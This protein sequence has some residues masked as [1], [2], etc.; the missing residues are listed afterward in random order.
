MKSITEVNSLYKTCCAICGTEDNAKELYPANIESSNFNP[1]VFSARRLPDRLHYRIVKCNTCGLVRSDPVASLDVIAKLYAQ[2]T[3]DYNDEVKGLKLTYGYYLDKLDKYKVQKRALL[4]IGCGNGF[5]LEE[6]LKRGYSTVK[7]VEPSKNAVSKANNCVQPNIICDIMSPGLFEP[8]YFDVICM[9][10]VLDHISNPNVLIKE[11]YNILKPG[12]IILCLNHN[13][14]SLSAKILKSRSPIIDI[15][16][17]YLFSPNTISHIFTLYN[18]QIKTVG[19]VYNNY[20][21]YYLIR[22]LP[23]GSNIKNKLLTLFNNIGRNIH[24][25]VPLGNLYLIAQK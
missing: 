8:E 20:S 23:L 10:Q 24:L 17:T 13:V 18:F 22:L 3:F 12:G 9:F 25:T 21:L 14:E 11:C 16:H 19:N 6:A 4:E 5:F 15:E 2:S 1:A 7:G